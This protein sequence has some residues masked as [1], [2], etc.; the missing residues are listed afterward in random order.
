MCH[1]CDMYVKNIA[2]C[3]M[4]F[5]R[6]V[7]IV[8]ALCFP[9]ASAPLSYFSY[10]FVGIVDGSGELIGLVLLRGHAERDT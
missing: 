9:G 6:A 7:S 10:I 3:Y 1:A 8:T 5:L 2:T 4:L